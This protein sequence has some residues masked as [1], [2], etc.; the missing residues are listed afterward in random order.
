MVKFDVF[1]VWEL[2]SISYALELFSAA[3]ADRLSESDPEEPYTVGGKL[4][5]HDLASYARTLAA[6]GAMYETNALVEWA[7]LV[8]ACWA[9]PCRD[10]MREAERL[11]RSR[12]ANE[13]TIEESYEI[14]ID[15]LPG[16]AELQELRAD[17]NALKHRGGEYILQNPDDSLETPG[18]VQC[19][20][21]TARRHVEAAREFLLALWSRV[22]PLQ[23]FLPDPDDGATG[24][25]GE[26]DRGGPYGSN[27]RDWGD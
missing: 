20:L 5:K 4:P 2:E 13:R 27:S 7:I 16:Y 1:L 12:T 3:A 23:Q 15:G 26:V 24:E 19:T 9:S 18:R 6:R 17:L 22:A 14:R 10:D 25:D 21:E 11:R 8:F